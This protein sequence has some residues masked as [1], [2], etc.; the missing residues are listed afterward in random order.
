MNAYDLN[1]LFTDQEVL[2]PQSLMVHCIKK[3]G[4]GDTGYND[5]YQNDFGGPCP[6]PH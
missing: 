1:D 6:I 4:E 2:T 3:S 5:A